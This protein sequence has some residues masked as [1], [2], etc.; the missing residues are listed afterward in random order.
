M[1][2][3]AR[4]N[5]KKK[6]KLLKIAVFAFLCFVV[7]T[8]IKLQVANAE[9][10][11]YLRALEENNAILAQQNAQARI[12]LDEGATQEN[13]ERIARESLDYAYPDEIIYF[14]L[15]N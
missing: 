4:K 9:Q 1:A 3:N 8:I 2:Q 14:D 10:R 11:A 13:I 12:E 15:P 7:Y 6:S 5:T